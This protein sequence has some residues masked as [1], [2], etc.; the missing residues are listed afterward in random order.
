MVESGFSLAKIS[1]SICGIIELMSI[2]KCAKCGNVIAVKIKR[3]G[4][5]PGNE[6]H[7]SLAHFPGHLHSTH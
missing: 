6:V 7:F 2:I 5:K 3:P 1:A 4:T